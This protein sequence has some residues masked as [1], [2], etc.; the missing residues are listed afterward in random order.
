MNQEVEKTGGISRRSFLKFAA[1][2]AGT[3]TALTLNPMASGLTVFG[4]PSKTLALAT[5]YPGSISGV[6]ANEIQ[7]LALRFKKM[8]EERTDIKV[9]I[10]PGGELGSEIEYTREVQKGKT[11]QSSLL[12]SGAWSSFQRKYQIMTTPYLFRDNLVAWEFFDSEF[13]ADFMSDLPE[14]GL[15]YLGTEDDGGGFVALTN[16]VHQVRTPED[17][18]GLRI[19]TEENPAHVAVMKALG[20]KA[21][22]MPWG[23]VPTALAT[24]VA[25]GQ[26]NASSILVWVKMWETQKYVSQTKHIYNTE[27]W[28]ISERF[29]QD[30]LIP[31]ERKAILRSARQALNESRGYARLLCYKAWDVLVENGMEVYFPTPDE[32]QK[33]K[34]IGRPGFLEWIVDDFGIPEKE[35]KA[36]WNKVDEID[37]QIDK[38]NQRLYGLG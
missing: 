31:D 19:R 17:L 15:R 9:E 13:M 20:A 12:S 23:E 29:Y 27:S 7:F 6:T 30:E 33:F 26:F 2:T 35:V 18:K 4:Q 16:S 5:I 1:G 37:Q 3:L 10:F 32:I 34:E 24:G 25:D 8:V 14:I 21:L 36:V 11:V 28:V 22:P 38:E